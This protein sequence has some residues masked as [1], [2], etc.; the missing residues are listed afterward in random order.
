MFKDIFQL[1][2]FILKLLIKI[3]L[4]CFKYIGWYFKTISEL[5][6][7]GYKK[8]KKKSYSEREIL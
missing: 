8:E 6:K 3:L 7:F 4:F 1:I 2:G 5:I